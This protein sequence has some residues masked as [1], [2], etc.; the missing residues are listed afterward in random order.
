M[1]AKGKYKVPAALAAGAVAHVGAGTLIRNSMSNQNNAYVKS[2]N[3]NPDFRNKVR[4]N[5]N[6]KV[7]YSVGTSALRKDIKDG[8]KKV[9]EADLSR[10]D[11][12][13][14]SSGYLDPK[15]V[16]TAGAVSTGLMIG[17]AGFA[18]AKGLGTQITRSAA[19]QSLA[20]EGNALVQERAKKLVL[21]GSK[22]KGSAIPA[23]LA[24][25]AA[26]AYLGHSLYKDHAH[27]RNAELTQ[28]ALANPAFK[29]R[30]EESPKHMLS[31]PATAGV[32]NAGIDAAMG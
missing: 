18:A 20:H 22:I 4:D 2:F 9:A 31:H 24:L 7:N 12:Y 15:G 3:E 5:M 16:S 23:G 17:G 8:L 27:S 1:L 28:K 10:F 6:S 13:K 21:L 29:K 25:G 19:R 14:A 30:L 11:K 32:M 26:G